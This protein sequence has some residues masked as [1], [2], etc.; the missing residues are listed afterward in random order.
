MSIRWKNCPEYISMIDLFENDPWN[1]YWSNHRLIKY[2]FQVNGYMATM[3][4]DKKIIAN[5]V[6]GWLGE[7]NTLHIE[8]F[9]IDP[10]IK[11]CSYNV[12]LSLLEF[13]QKEHGITSTDN[14]FIESYFK[15]AK[16]INTELMNDD[17]SNSLI[18]RCSSS[19]VEGIDEH[20]TKN[21]LKH[22]PV[23]SK[24]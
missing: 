14:L 4:D 10:G 7:I 11:V 6:V 20:L 8:W 22:D 1:D 18:H 24:L 23:V 9:S 17:P 15:N 3:D 2:K 13:I 5:A 19:L 12:W 16:W 21:K